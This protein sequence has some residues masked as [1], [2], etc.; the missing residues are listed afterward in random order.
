[1]NCNIDEIRSRFDKSLSVLMQNLGP[2]L[3]NRVQLGL[4]PGQVI[5]LHFIYR[6]N[7]CCLSKLAE[8]LEVSPSAIT[9][10]VDRLENQGIVNRIRDNDDRRVVKVE[11]TG[12]GRKKINQV[13]QLRNEIIQHCLTQIDLNKIESFLQ[14]LE[15]LAS[16]TQEIDVREFL[17]I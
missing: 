8:M 4:T 17:V 14:T 9:I 13:Y 3:I 16:I 15:T 11:L 2:Q 5:M 7:Q 12:V 10:M 6:E 1:M